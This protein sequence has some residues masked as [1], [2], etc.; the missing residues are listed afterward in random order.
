MG[1]RKMRSEDMSFVVSL[2]RKE[3]WT[4]APVE[5][6]RMLRLDPEG[7]LIYEDGEPFG[8]VNTVTYGKTGFIGILVVSEKGRGR[9]I[10]QSLLKEALSYCESRGT[11]SILLYATAEGVK[12]YEKHGF[13]KCQD[14][15]CIRAEIRPGDFALPDRECM[16]VRPGDL[17]RILEIDQE[18]FGDDRSRLIRMLYDEYPRNAFKVERGG[19][20]VGY[21]FGRKT[22]LTVDFGPWVCTTGRREDAAAL[23]NRS[24]SSLGTGEAYF[25]VF[26]A[27]REAMSLI[28]PIKKIRTW[29]TIQ[30]VRG[31]E[32]YQKHIDQVF[33]VVG[34]ELG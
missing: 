21:A 17:G 28:E 34:F 33:G 29:R 10:G 4:Y 7:S 22:A 31:E 1:I 26:D 16:P 5:I 8:V 32:R 25:G 24:M 2:V 13:R 27:N 9:R 19:D 20:I 23:L 3:G 11:N 18:V 15:H 6:E 12:L 30:M 14:V